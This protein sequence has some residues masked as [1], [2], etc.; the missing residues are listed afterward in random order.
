MKKGKRYRQA[1][2]TVDPAKACT[3]AEALGTIKAQPSV[4]FDETIEIAIRTGLD[5]KKADQAL[6]GTISL[7]NGIGKT[8]RVIAFCP[9][10]QVE[11]AKAAGAIEAGGE[12][13]VQKVSGGWLEFVA[14]AATPTMRFV[15]KLGRVLGPKGLMPSPKSG[16]VVDDIPAA[17]KEFVAGKIEYRLDAGGNIHAPVGKKSFSA[18]ALA[19]N[20]HAFIEQVVR[21]KPSSVKGK[22]IRGIT[23]ASTMGPGVKVAE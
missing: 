12:E 17:V 6:R 2:T 3:V 21:A 20:V 14:V 23:L 8:L 19:A 5:P 16:T 13:L 11:A 7:P 9:P 22:Y 4:K 10:D 15:G 18:E 1:L